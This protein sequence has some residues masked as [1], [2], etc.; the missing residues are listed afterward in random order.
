MYCNGRELLYTVFDRHK[1]AG[2]RRGHVRVPVSCMNRSND[3]GSFQSLVNA[4]NNVETGSS[5]TCA[6]RLSTALEGL[7]LDV[8]HVSSRRCARETAVGRRSSMMILD[9]CTSL[10]HACIS[11][12]PQSP[13]K[14]TT[15]TT[16][17]AI[18]MPFNFFVSQPHRLVSLRNVGISGR[19]SS[20]A[21]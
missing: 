15:F 9:A 14:V 7:V 19:V 11:D 20:R 8:A 12:R 16:A 17:C 13:N 3:T 21:A 6:S 10:Q 18:E 2:R 5:D 1:E 4:T